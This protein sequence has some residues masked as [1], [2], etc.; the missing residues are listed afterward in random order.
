VVFKSSKIVSDK[1]CFCVPIFRTVPDLDEGIVDEIIKISAITKMEVNPDDQVHRSILF[2]LYH[3]LTQKDTTEM[4]GNQWMDIGFLSGDPATEFR[5]VGSL[6]LLFLMYFIEEGTLSEKM[7]AL[8]LEP[9]T[10]YKSSSDPIEIPFNYCSV[11]FWII[12]LEYD[13]IW[14]HERISEHQEGRKTDFIYV[15]HQ[16]VLGILQYVEKIEK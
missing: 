2:T 12:S 14:V 16:C 3:Q 6:G 7:Y 8:S 5:G 10:V 13:Q 9:K 1:L 11:E 4:K 15:F